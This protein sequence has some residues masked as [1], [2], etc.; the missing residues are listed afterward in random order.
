M[1]FRELRT[2][3]IAGLIPLVRDIFAENP[4]ATWFRSEPQNSEL[5]EMFADKIVLMRK[6][7]AQDIVALDGERIVGEC[8]IIRVRSNDA[9][10]GIIVAREYRRKGVATRMLQRCTALAEKVGITNL[11]VEVSKSNAHAMKFFTASGFGEVRND[12]AYGKSGGPDT[13]LLRKEIA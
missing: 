5:E 9:A 2:E 4:S 12:D 10:V 6:G 3:D 1:R 8:E 13:V 11:Y 7:D